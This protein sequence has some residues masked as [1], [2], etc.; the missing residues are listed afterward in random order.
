MYMVFF[1]WGLRL[2]IGLG[3]PGRR[4][5]GRDELEFRVLHKKHQ[6]RGAIGFLIS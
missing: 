6:L 4:L 3:G 2:R 1:S 5:A